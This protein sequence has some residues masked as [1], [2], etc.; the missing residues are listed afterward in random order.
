MRPLTI[1]Q[2][3]A[4]FISPYREPTASDVQGDLEMTKLGSALLVLLEQASEIMRESDRKWADSVVALRQ[5]TF[6]ATP[7]AAL[8]EL[9]IDRLGPHD[10]CYAIREIAERAVA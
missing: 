4:S 5:R 2:A 3:E 6:K 10:D 8:A 1:E 7:E 9:L